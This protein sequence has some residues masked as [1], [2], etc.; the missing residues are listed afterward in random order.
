MFKIGDYVYIT[1]DNKNGRVSG[2]SANFK[3]GETNYEVN[4][5]E[6]TFLYSEKELKSVV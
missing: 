6:G 1:T 2:I 4:I 3:T 5:G